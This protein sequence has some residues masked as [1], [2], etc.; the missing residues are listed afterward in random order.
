[1]EG[2]GWKRRG[3]ST[4]C[5]GRTKITGAAPNKRLVGFFD[6]ESGCE[7]YCRCSLGAFRGHVCLRLLGLYQV[8]I[9]LAWRYFNLMHF[10][11]VPF[12]FFLIHSAPEKKVLSCSQ[13]LLLLE[14][15]QSDYMGFWTISDT[16]SELLSEDKFRFAD[17]F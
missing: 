3:A 7:E 15:N 6:A 13:S 10:V 1:M 9:L 17:F 8:M 14:W 16:R 2:L 5:Q 12:L 4:S 11:P